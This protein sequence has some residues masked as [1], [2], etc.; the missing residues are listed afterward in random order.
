MP[1]EFLQVIKNDISALS[2]LLLNNFF[3]MFSYSK[4]HKYSGWLPIYS[5]KETD[6]K[7]KQGMESDEVAKPI[8]ER[9]EFARD[10]DKKKSQPEKNQEPAFHPL[11]VNPK[12]VEFE[13]VFYSSL[14]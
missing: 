10:R 14:K 8:Q 9:G 5:K 11:F 13:N 6:G 1:T 3:N 12:K 4:G 7:K 2:S